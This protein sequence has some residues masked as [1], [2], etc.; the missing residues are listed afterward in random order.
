MIAEVS[1]FIVQKDNTVLTDL[2]VF[3]LF[4]CTDSKDQNWLQRE[5][6]RSMILNYHSN[7]TSDLIKD[8]SR[9][10]SKPGE[11]LIIKDEQMSDNDSNHSGFLLEATD[12]FSMGQSDEDA[13]KDVEGKAIFYVEIFTA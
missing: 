10:K 8:G 2:I 4:V 12:D 1:K 13:E 6:R 11:K 7:S 9:R 3:L 5:F